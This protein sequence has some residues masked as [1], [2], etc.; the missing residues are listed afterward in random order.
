[1]TMLKKAAA[2]V[3]AVAILMV[4]VPCVMLQASAKGYDRISDPSTMD[5]WKLYF[6][7]DVLSTENAGGV[8][9]DKSVFTDASA[10]DGT[11]ITMSDR[12]DNFL[13]ALSAM[14]SDTAVKGYANTPTDVMLVLD[15]SSDMASESAVFRCVND[16]IASVGQL[17]YYNRVGVTVYD[18]KNADVLLALDRY[19]YLGDDTDYSFIKPTYAH[20]KLTS[21]EVNSRVINASGETVTASYAIIDPD[22]S[23]TQR[24]V[25]TALEELLAADPLISTEAEYFAG[26]TRMPVLTLIT[27]GKP[28]AATTEYTAVGE[29]TIAASD[30]IANVAQRYF[31]TQL[32][33]SYAEECLKA[34]YSE[35]ACVFTVGLGNDAGQDILNPYLSDKHSSAVLKDPSSYTQD[36]LTAAKINRISDGYWDVLLNDGHLDIT[37]EQDVQTVSRVPLQDTDFPCEKAQKYIAEEWFTVSDISEIGTL[38]DAF[39]GAIDLQSRYYPTLVDGN[40][41]IS[42]Y[43]SFRDRI[44]EHMSITDI[45][46]ILIDNVLF[47]G[48]MLSKNFI[49]GGGELGTYDSPTSL[50]DELVWAVKSRLG[51]DADTARDLLG[52]AYYHGQLHYE[53]DTDFSNY[54]GWYANAVG[55]FLGFWYDGMTTMPDPADPS[56][57]D[58]TRP[59]YIIRSYGFLGAVD[60]EHGVAQSDLMYATV[61]IRESLAT[62]NED[63]LFSIPAALIPTVTYELSFDENDTLETFHVGGA[64][65]PVRL[66][67]EVALDDGIDPVTIHKLSENGY[68]HQNEDGSVDFYSNAFE[69]DDTVG[70]GKSNAICYFTPS[71]TNA[72]YYYTEN[73]LIYADTNGTVYSGEKPD[74]QAALYRAYHVH[75][76]DNGL[77]SQLVYERIS[78]ESLE[79]AVSGEDG[80]MIPAGTVHTMLS[81]YVTDKKDN[82]TDTLSCSNVPFVDTL[83]TYYVGATLGNNGRLTLVP[84]TGLLL[85]ATVQDEDTE[86][87]TFTISRT[88]T[89]ENAVYTATVYASD[90]APREQTVSFRNGTAEVTLTAG[91]ELYIHGLQDGA[92]YSIREAEN[93]EYRLIGVNGDSTLS[94]ATVT[95]RLH[96]LSKAVFENARRGNGGV[97]IVNRVTHD[98]G[99]S[100]EIPDIRFTYLVDLPEDYADTEIA[101]AYSEDPSLTSV[102][103]DASGSF[104]IT[105][106]HSDQ[107]E[108][109][110]LTDGTVVHVTQTD[111]PA[112]FTPVYYGAGVQGAS[113]VTIHEN[114]LVSIIVSN[115]YA[116]QPV[117]NVDI[118]V[119][120]TLH[121]VGRDNDEWLDVDVYSFELQRYTDGVWKT[122]AVDAV[123]LQKPS[124]SFAEAME[125]ERYEKS[126]VY[127]YQIVQTVG[128]VTGVLYDRTIHTFS[129]T[130]GDRGMCGRLHVLDVTSHHK[131]MYVSGSEADGWTITTDFTNLFTSS[132]RADAVI[133]IDKQML[134]TSNSDL[135]SLAGFRFGLFADTGATPVFVSD[136]TDGIGEA[137]LIATFDAVGTYTYTLRELAPDTPVAGMQY[138]NEM[139]T[140]AIEVTETENGTL[141]AETSFFKDGEVVVGDPVFT[142]TYAPDAATVSPE[143]RVVLT[144][145][146]LSGGEFT[147]HIRE[148]ETV[149]ATGINTADGIVVFDHALTF[150]AIGHYYYDVIEYAGDLKGVDYDPKVYRL[151]VTVTD[152]GNGELHAQL[153]VIN[154]A[155]NV[156]TFKN[157]YNATPTKLVISG[158]KYLIG[159]ELINE[160]FSFVLINGRTILSTSNYTDGTFRFEPITFYEVGNYSLSVVE[161]HESTTHGIDFDDTSYDVMVTVTDDGNGSLNAQMTIT[162]NGEETDEIVFT[163]YYTTSPAQVTLEGVQLLEGR[164]QQAGEFTI[165]LY[166]ADEH[167]SIAD[168]LAVTVNDENGAFLFDTLTFV[169]AGV[170]RFIVKAAQGGET[171]DGVT[172][173]AQTYRVL[174]VV[175]DNRRG[176]LSASAT[177]LN[178]SNEYADAMVF[179]NAYTTPTSTTTTTTTPTT[180]VEASP[181]TTTTTPT[182]STVAPATTTTTTSNPPTGE[183]SDW[184]LWTLLVA[185]GG[186]ITLLAMRQKQR[187]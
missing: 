166:E 107:F 98:F 146:A 142:N 84:D 124:F 7:E 10:F 57:T 87:F 137:R 85:K 108:L 114:T 80:W 154:T 13:V 179:R 119:D 11:G 187:Q 180:T 131:G 167:W 55:E 159:R 174:V 100:Y 122:I 77:I 111:T 93:A 4:S 86:S 126:G 49:T 94:Q 2:I 19:E 143:I 59:V 42:G 40:E 72:R 145:K 48:A 153:H 44:G 54:I 62:G 139:Y 12:G 136:A 99:A 106:G 89:A 22:G 132:A 178:A 182:T 120:G 15:L 70:Y 133:D 129:V 5:D 177:I 115:V 35:N 41:D 161:V 169:R 82:P 185:V 1:M 140:V 8:W 60:E 75:G 81:P 147:V 97:T 156:I 76:Y 92:S 150:S 46:G 144:G 125:A 30:D 148:G 168:P 25:L 29:A 34:H 26:Q 113:A 172:Y 79:K 170:Y 117:E 37:V 95:I 45:K 181:T 65:H 130:V 78:P 64:E 121:L 61:Q 68:R 104:T 28:T 47:S 39:V 73:T 183:T 53:N 17:G 90:R 31:L 58:A 20:G 134:N 163:N 149:L 152:G 27:D 16:A 36:E 186:M 96:T 155:S 101:V 63:M 112:G 74:K 33:L 157:L 160:E 175:T 102:T 173:D 158:K 110:E 151:H 128:E 176:A 171:V 135:V 109:R 14:A 52:L 66:V 141:R 127:S 71:G 43:I 116:Y 105:L 118:S 123:D 88:D 9:T 138:S 91:E 6:G 69:E 83:Y 50:G 3:L 32:T 103:T 164:D 21:V 67:Y 184:M 51:V 38:A 56:L 165:E 162:C 23:Y 18:G 24:G